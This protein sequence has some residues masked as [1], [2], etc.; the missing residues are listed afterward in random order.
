[1]FFL[2][3]RTVRAPVPW[4]NSYR[5]AK[6]SC[7]KNLFITNPVMMKIQNLWYDRYAR[8]VSSNVVSLNVKLHTE[9]PSLCTATGPACISYHLLF[10]RICLNV[11]TQFLT[12]S[13]HVYFPYSFAHMFDQVYSDTVKRRLRLLNYWSLLGFN[14]FQICK[15]VISNP[16]CSKNTQLKIH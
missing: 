7:T 14:P 16:M 11:K 9:L 15:V 2:S 13:V 10:G 3:L 4:H 8:R 1:M 12:S 6:E 5:S